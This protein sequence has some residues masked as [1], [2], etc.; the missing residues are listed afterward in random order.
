MP[1]KSS[2][3]SEYSEILGARFYQ[4][5]DAPA[6]RILIHPA[7]MAKSLS[8]NGANSLIDFYIRKEETF[9]I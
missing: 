2:E 4:T 6:D 8:Y 9:H 7:Q 5:N 3:Y 1:E